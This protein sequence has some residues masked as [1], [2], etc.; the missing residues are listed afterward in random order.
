MAFSS[1][2]KPLAPYARSSCCLGDLTPP[3]EIGG[4]L[5][6]STRMPCPACSIIKHEALDRAWQ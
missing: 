6:E 2:N 4:P 5:K 1:V 3:I